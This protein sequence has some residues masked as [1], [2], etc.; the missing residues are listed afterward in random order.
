MLGRY[1][2]TWY[3]DY[4]GTSFASPTFAEPRR[5]GEQRAPRRGQARPRSHAGPILYQTP[6]VQATFRDIATGATATHAA[7]PGWDY[8]TG[9]GAPDAL[10][11]ATSM[12]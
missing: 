2:A 7:G 8:P 5:R 11:L 3:G 6:A 10:G 1:L 12:P 4:G 9:W